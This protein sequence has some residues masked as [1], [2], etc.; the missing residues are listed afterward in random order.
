M[1]FLTTTRLLFFPPN[2]FGHYEPEDYKQLCKATPIAR[3]ALPEYLF[4]CRPSRE[5]LPPVLYLGWNMGSEADLTAFL[6]KYDPELVSLKP[7]GGLTDDSLFELRYALHE[8]F[9]ISGAMA[10]LLQMSS[11]WNERGEDV[12]ALTVGGNY[13][14]SCL[15]DD[16]I[17]KIGKEINKDE[18]SW[19]LDEDDWYWQ[20]GPET[21]AG[22]L[23]EQGKLLITPYVH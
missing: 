22:R 8:R 11:V 6:L 3:D 5:L 21:K 16:L 18:P 19:W 23:A 17:E 7:T 12:W 1:P 2:D 13:A 4:D 15:P 9:D 20:P 14:G 10:D